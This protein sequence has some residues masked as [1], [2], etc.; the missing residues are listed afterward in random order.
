MIK[1]L[2]ENTIYNSGKLNDY[3]ISLEKKYNIVDEVDKYHMLVNFSENIAVPFHNWFRYREGYSSKLIQ[4]LIELSN[5]NKGEIIIDPFCGS[6][7]TIVESI[8][9]GYNSI[10]VDVN[11]MSAFITSAKSDMYSS[12]TLTECKSLIKNLDKY[13]PS[14]LPLELYDEVRKFFN[15]ANFINLIRIKY[16][17]ETK[18]DNPQAQQLFKLCFL[19][20]IE[21]SSNRKR[22]GNGLKTIPTKIYNV[23]LYFKLK[24][25]IIIN[26]LE[27]LSRIND[28]YGK[29]Y[30]GSSLMLREFVNDFVDKYPANV[31]AIMFSPP[32]PNSFD[33]FESY[34]L[35]LILGD[36]ASNIKEINKYRGQAVCSFVGNN[37]IINNSDYYIDLLAKE[38]EQSIPIKEHLTGKRDSRTRKV[39]N[40][41]R[42]YF[43]D[44]NNIIQECAEC[45][46]EG[47]K[48]F[49]V[50]DQSAYLGKIVPTDLLLAAGAEKFGFNVKKIIICRRAKTSGQQLQRFPYLKNCLRESIV[51]LIKT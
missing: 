28:V 22:D 45:L 2:N 38:I 21:E 14:S 24:L 46:P 18:I 30:A 13:L 3:I 6:G 20:I 10:G 1:T 33:Y 5:I 31:G 41:I 42:S 36:F 39:P 16:Y 43:T 37:G 12:E 26:D 8:L 29:G 17:I 23:N 34:K 19:S 9:N 49:I 50:V 11:P 51:E 25:N 7:T 15:T 32:Y 4:H 27:S 40:M 35:E 44:M 48:C 47:K